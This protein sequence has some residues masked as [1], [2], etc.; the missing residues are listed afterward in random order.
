[1]PEVF[2]MGEDILECH[3]FMSLLDGIHDKNVKI[4]LYVLLF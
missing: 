4:P 1:M 3:V 2:I